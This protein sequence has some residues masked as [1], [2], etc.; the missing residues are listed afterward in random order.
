MFF[1]KQNP[2]NNTSHAQI[3]LFGKLARDNN[4]Q[5]STWQAIGQLAATVFFRN[6]LFSPPHKLSTR[7]Y[8]ASK[9]VPADPLG[10]PT[11]LEISSTK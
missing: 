1:K 4:Q 6:T 9:V 8:A 7:V 10:Q 2:K 11:T 3:I 5:W